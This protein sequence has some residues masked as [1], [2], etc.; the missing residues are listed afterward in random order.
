MQERIE[1]SILSPLMGGFTG[2]RHGWFSAWPCQ[3]II[4]HD[5]FG[6]GTLDWVVAPQDVHNGSKLVLN[7][8]LRCPLK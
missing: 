7:S 6:T 4:A 3:S 8:P 5:T 1:A 2:A